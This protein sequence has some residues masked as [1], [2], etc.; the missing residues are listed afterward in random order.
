[1]V[2]EE[3]VGYWDQML[4]LVISILLLFIFFTDVFPGNYNLGV[5][6]ISAA[7]MYTAV[8]RSCEPYTLIGFKTSDKTRPI[9]LD[10]AVEYLV[11]VAAFYMVIFLLKF[12]L[13]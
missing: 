11:G 8:T 4:R 12:Y 6:L 2:R 10:T 1:M 3:N 7:L 5:L 9:P 13:I